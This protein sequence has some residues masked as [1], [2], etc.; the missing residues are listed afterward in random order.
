[1][2]TVVE[3]VDIAGLV[4]GASQGE[5]LGNQFLSHIRETHAIAHLVR[6]FED[7]DVT[8]VAGKIDPLHD[9]E[10]IDTELM[11]AD[12]ETVQKTFQRA[13]RAAKS[14]EKAAVA[15]RDVLQKVMQALAEGRPVRGLALDPREAAELEGSAPAH[16]QAG[17]VHRERGRGLARRQSARRARSSDLAEEQGAEWV[18]ISAALEAELAQLPQAE[19]ADFPVEPRARTSPA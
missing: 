5:G 6:C 12:L 3:F 16:G 13:E 14:N 11:L 9:I 2:P 7:D 15:R 4:E 17:D 1:M 19:R 18:V 8:H 10:I